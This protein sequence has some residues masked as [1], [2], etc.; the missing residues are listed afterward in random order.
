MIPSEV[1]GRPFPGLC[2]DNPECKR[3]KFR[4][5]LSFYRYKEL[6]PLGYA[7]DGRTIYGPYRQDGELW[8]PCDVDVCNGRIIKGEY[9]YVA[10]SFYPYFVGCWGPGT[11]ANFYA[12]CTFNPRR[13][14]ET[15]SSSSTLIFALSSVLML[16]FSLL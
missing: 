10:T 13:C 9:A 1:V 7:K 8:Q 4:Y 15:A 11:R 3:N 14:F 12:S 6:I 5:A 16:L 2:E